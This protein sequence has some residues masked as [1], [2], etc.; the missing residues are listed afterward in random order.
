M[1]VACNNRG[2]D[3]RNQYFAVV[4]INKCT[5]SMTNNNETDLTTH[6]QHTHTYTHTH[7][8]AHTHAHTH[9]PPSIQQFSNSS[10]LDF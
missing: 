10:N 2:H 9:T 7:T 8:H 6:I 1:C 3:A 4:K 5:F